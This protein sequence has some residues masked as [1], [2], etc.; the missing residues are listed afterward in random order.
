MDK[1]SVMEN[2]L[3]TVAYSHSNSKQTRAAYT[4]QFQKFLD[5]VEK[6]PEQVVKEY[7]RSSDRKFKRIY[8]Q[9]LMALIRE[10]Q[11]LKYAPSSVNSVINVV[12]SFFK[13]N[14]LP[15]GFIPSGSNLIEFHNRD[16]DKN[17]VLEVLRLANIRD[18]AF[19]CILTQS[20]LRPSTIAK[21]KIK[22]MEK[23]LAQDTPIPCKINV[24]QENTKGKYSEYFSF[25]G[26]E[27]VTYLK[28]YL[29][30]KGKVLTEEDYVFSKFGKEQEKPLD[31]GI[32]T[33]MFE[34]IV[35]RLRDGK[36]LDFKTSRKE[37]DVKTKTKE[38]LRD[39]IS[40]SDIRL[41]NLRKYFRKYAGQA[42][43]DYVQYWMGHTS[44]LGVDLHYFSKDVELHRKIYREKAMPHLR[45]ET[46]TVSESQTAIN[47]LTQRLIQKDSEF[48]SMK[49]RLAEMESTYLQLKAVLSSHV[50]IQAEGVTPEQ[51]EKLKRAL[52]L[53]KEEPPREEG[54]QK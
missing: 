2:W 51:V 21:L 3:S 17:E 39:H 13:Y 53:A 30:T 4:T 12:R 20:G 5:F 35:K 49:A 1:F 27:S 9:Y 18:R 48:E 38:H 43:P 40:R 37:M 22:D 32:L 19:F 45:L 25:I 34:R 54:S 46:A 36:V 14:D 15:L 7:E 10:L 42:G 31:A 44:S 29:K 41:Y 52:R 23:I 6:T 16:I 11:A 26:E 8:A 24:R 33:H 50:T 28:D 47:E